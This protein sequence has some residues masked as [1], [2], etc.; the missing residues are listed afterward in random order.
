MLAILLLVSVDMREFYRFSNVE[1][2][3]ICEHLKNSISY[4]CEILSLQIILGS[5]KSSQ[6][7]LSDLSRVCGTYIEITC[8]DR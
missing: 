6:S 4:E 7:P 2:Q 1:L 3:C 8:Q 5:R